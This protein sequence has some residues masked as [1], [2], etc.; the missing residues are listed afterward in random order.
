M[1][2]TMRSLALEKSTARSTRSF[3]FGACLAL[4]A[5]VPAPSVLAATEIGQLDPAADP[6]GSCMGTV[7]FVQTEAVGDPSYAVPPGGSVITG[8]SHKANLASGRELGLKLLRSQ[9]DGTFTVVGGSEMEVLEPSTVNTFPTRVPAQGGD[10]LGLWI[11]NPPMGGPLDFGGGA[12]CAFGAAS[13]NTLHMGFYGAE[14]AVGATSALGGDYS[15]MRLNVTATVEP[16]VDVDGY[17]DESQDGC[18]AD[19]ATQDACPSGSPPPPPVGSGAPASRWLKFGGRTR[20][21]VGD[22]RIALRVTADRPVQLFVRGRIAIGRRG[23]AFALRPVRRILRTAVPRTVELKLSRK[24]RRSVRRA[25]KRGT[26][27]TAELSIVAIDNAN[28][29]VKATRS[30]RLAR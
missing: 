18:P 4:A 25:L 20:D 8:W 6:G 12:S 27:A 3:V 22:L 29:R 30:I 5:L 24:M 19:A 14:P 11:G 26:E 23:N 15:G 28:Q 17:G 13:G 1:G 21:S 9:G 10:L 7:V 2:V 16:D